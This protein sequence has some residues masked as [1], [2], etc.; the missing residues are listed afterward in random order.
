MSDSRNQLNSETGPPPILI[1]NETELRAC[2]T[3]NDE[4][5]AAV[6]TG[7][8][9]LARGNATV[10]PIMIVDVADQQGEVDVKSAYVHGLDSFAVK[11]ASGFFGNTKLGLPSGS[12]LMILVSAKT[13]FPQA[14]LLDN[15]YLTHLRTGLAGAIAAKH[16][17]REQVDV[18]GIIGGGMQGRYQAQ[19]LQ[20]VRDFKLAMVYDEDGTALARYVAEM[21]AELGI[22][23]TAAGDASEVVQNS[24]VVVTTTP[25]K[26][27][28]LMAD[29]LHPGIHITAMGSDSPEKQEL[30]TAVF[31][32]TD[33]VA[34]DRLSQC[35]THGELHHALDDGI[36]AAE[37]AASEIG[38]IAVGAKPG[39]TNDE[40]ITLCDLTGVGVQDT[41][42][43]LLAYQ[44]AL[45]KGLGLKIE[46]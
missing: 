42:I 36:I 30:D 41:A 25:S 16:L 38:A 34:C 45:E 32:R 17:A 44:K 20:L 11:I 9:Q 5:L 24:D 6:E 33:V 12:G 10:P 23:V 13:G 27:P 46:A 21:S 14:V 31:L 18:L 2:A 8:T 4:A 26:S 28:F 1:L 15:G 3:M 29:W 19:A 39:R 22:D 37:N 35:L 7:F 43:A 40:E